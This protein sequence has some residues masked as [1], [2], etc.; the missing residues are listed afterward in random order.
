MI[1]LTTKTAVMAAP[2]WCK[3]VNTNLWKHKHKYQWL[4][5]GSNP[6]TFEFTATTPALY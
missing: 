2:S 6:T 3:N 1:K 5:T 4:K